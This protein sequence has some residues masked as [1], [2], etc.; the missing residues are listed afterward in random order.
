ERKT[1]G[2][3]KVLADGKGRVVG[4][5]IVGEG[6]GE[7]IN[8]WA[9]AVTHKMKLRDITAYVPPYPT[10]GEI[11]RRAAVSS[12]APATKKPLVRNV[13]SLLQKLG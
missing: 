9:F 11:G 1:L 13:I 6:A 2:L 3:I 4:A 7:I 5:S 8:M 12:F 10:M